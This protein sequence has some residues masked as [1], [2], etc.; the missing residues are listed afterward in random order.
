[1]IE[2]RQ[3]NELQLEWMAIAM[4]AIFAFSFHTV[5]TFDDGRMRCDWK[6]FQFP[7]SYWSLFCQT[8]IPVILFS[9]YFSLFF[10]IHF[11]NES[12]FWKLCAHLRGTDFL[13]Y[14]FFFAFFSVGF[15][16]F[17]T[18]YET[19][20]CK[21]TRFEDCLCIARRFAVKICMF[22]ATAAWKFCMKSIYCCAGL[23]L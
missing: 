21:R 14:Y 23:G 6:T 22:S 17:I 16:D 12:N 9:Y 2:L 5:D 20:E 18:S 7:S 8:N 3:R 19:T 4:T 10:S 15:Y 1:M 13:W 11:T